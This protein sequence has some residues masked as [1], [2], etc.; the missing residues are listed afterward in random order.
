[1]T[2]L[3]LTTA[4]FEVHPAA[5]RYESR[6]AIVTGAAR[7]LGRVIARRLAQE[8]ANVVVADIAEDR[9]R[10]C[11]DQLA[12]Q[13]GQQFLSFGGDLS[14]P[15]T[16]EALV[17]SALERF[18]QIDTLVNNA[19][20][21]V[22]LRLSDF[23]EELLQLSVDGNVWTTVRCCKAVIPH[24]EARGYGRIVNIGGEAW[25]AGTPYH[26]MLAGV[27]KG[28]VVG[29]TATL[30]GETAAKGVTVNCVSPGGM[31]TEADGDENPQPASYN[32]AW[33]DPNFFPEM[34][35]AASARITSLGR[36]AHPSEV[37][38]AVAFFGAPEA[39]FVT[40]QHLGVSGGAV[41]I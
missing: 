15:G 37:A 18:G 9:V 20:A 21:L 23:T 22:R 2:E 13:T 17:E 24:M 27:G 41:M 38:A 8:G 31:E 10:R 34:R 5:R 6:V 26:T 40:G 1:M 29:L 19:A 12:A 32:P 25:R 36:L 35:R 16:A 4:R 33:T 11:A 7:G 14:R 30:A 3:N 39:S 28:A